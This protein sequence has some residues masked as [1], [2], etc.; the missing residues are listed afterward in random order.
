M[1]AKGKNLTVRVVRIELT[2]SVLSGQRST[3]ELH[4]QLQNHSK[5]NLYTQT[6]NRHGGFLLILRSKFK[7]K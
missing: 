6:K 4:A 5:K 3:T 7:F 1:N 2:A